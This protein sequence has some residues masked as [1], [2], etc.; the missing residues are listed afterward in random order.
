[1]WVL[2]VCFVES[3]QEELD[4]FVFCAAF[5][6]KSNTQPH[7]TSELAEV[8]R[9]DDETCIVE[10]SVSVSPSVLLTYTREGH[11]SALGAEE[12]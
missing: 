10:S 12:Y 5:L 11:R 1:M 8:Q 4:F 7:V 2:E 3:T 6:D 9:R